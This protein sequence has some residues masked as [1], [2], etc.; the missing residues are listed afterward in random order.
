MRTCLARAGDAAMAAGA[1]SAALLTGYIEFLFIYGLGLSIS[2]GDLGWALADMCYL[3]IPLVVGAVVWRHLAASRRI[4]RVLVATLLAMVTAFTVFIG[5]Y[6]V[7]V[8]L[9]V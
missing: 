5:A 2:E 8:F 6:I 9:T 3:V 7:G 1:A 4:E